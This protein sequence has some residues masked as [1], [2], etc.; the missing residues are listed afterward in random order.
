[1]KHAVSFGRLAHRDRNRGRKRAGRDLDVIF[2][3][4]PLG[5]A[6]RRVWRVGVALEVLDL[7]AVDPAALVDHIAGD[8]HR[9]PVL[10]TVLGERPGQWQ[11]HADPDVFL[12]LRRKLR[13]ETQT[14]NDGAN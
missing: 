10:K 6:D 12:R 11:Q 9:F 14:R 8:L 1:M 4:Q 3:N 7:A 13:G 2:G 5:F